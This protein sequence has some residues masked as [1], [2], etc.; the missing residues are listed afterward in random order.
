M[1]GPEEVTVEGE[2]GDELV[3]ELVGESGGESVGEWVG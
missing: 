1:D 3:G 2:S